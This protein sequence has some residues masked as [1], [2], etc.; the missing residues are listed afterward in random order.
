MIR[1]IKITEATLPIIA[2]VNDGLMPEIE[3]VT[4]YYI[5]WCD[6]GIYNDVVDEHTLQQSFNFVNP[7]IENDWNEVVDK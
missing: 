4:T 2:Q 5:D 1:A 6:D 7:E 3:D